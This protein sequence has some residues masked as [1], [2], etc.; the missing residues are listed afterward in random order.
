V[1]CRDGALL[2][3]HSDVKILYAEDNPA[4]AEMTLRAFKKQKLIN[5][6]V[7]VK[8]GEEAIDYLFR[9]GLF[10]GRPE[11]HPNLVLLDLK[12]PKVDGLEVLKRIRASPE[13]KFTPV[14]ILTSSP[15]EIDI[16]RSYELG[17]NSYI[18]KP[19]N[20]ENFTETVRELGMYWILKNLKVS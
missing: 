13:L 14:V 10:D 16:L 5:S 3:N 9:E 11:G 12:M 6:V 17:V 8:N 15:D 2:K 20:L 19:V 18:A 7:W 1:A 4:D